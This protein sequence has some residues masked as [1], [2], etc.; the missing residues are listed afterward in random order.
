MP[1]FILTVANEKGPGSV[2]VVIAD[3]GDSALILLIQ[4]WL[5]V[6]AVRAR[7]PVYTTTL[8]EQCSISKSLFNPLAAQ[9][10]RIS[11]PVS[12]GHSAFDGRYML[13]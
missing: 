1:W 6:D 10:K 11:R 2:S 5:S 3:Q 4:C 13:S 8:C 7:H 9:C 12:M